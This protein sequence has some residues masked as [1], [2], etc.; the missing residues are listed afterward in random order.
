MSFNYIFSTF[1]I[2]F[3]FVL[4]KGIKLENIFEYKFMLKVWEIYI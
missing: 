4:N 3:R 1:A 2:P